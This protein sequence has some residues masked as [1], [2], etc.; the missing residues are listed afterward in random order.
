MMMACPAAPPRPILD[1]IPLI[2][3]CGETSKVRVI[4]PKAH[5]CPVCHAQRSVGII[6]TDANYCYCK[7]RSGALPCAP[8]LLAAAGVAAG[9]AR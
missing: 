9:A 1:F 5:N 7:L 3:V 2:C 8:S 6:A 4:D